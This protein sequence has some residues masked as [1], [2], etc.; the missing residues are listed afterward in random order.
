MSHE[1]KLADSVLHRVI[2]ILQEALLMGVDVSDLMRQIRLVLSD[3]DNTSDTG[4]LVLSPA[5]EKQV[6]E[7]HEK[8]LKQAEDLANEEREKKLIIGTN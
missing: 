3:E 4:T 6:N 2:Q 8:L 1:M 5:Y 7:M